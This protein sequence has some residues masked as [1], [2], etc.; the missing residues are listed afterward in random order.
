MSSKFDL[1]KQL[2]TPHQQISPADMIDYRQF[3]VQVDNILHQFK[4][5]VRESEQVLQFIQNNNNISQ[6]QYKQLLRQHRAI[7]VDLSD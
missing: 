7:R 2:Q 5:P 4:V 6:Q 1:I 3:E